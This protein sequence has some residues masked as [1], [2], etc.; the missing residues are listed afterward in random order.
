MGNENP[1]VLRNL[2]KSGYWIILTGH[3]TLI[4]HYYPCKRAELDINVNVGLN[5]V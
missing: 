5:D 2:F 3:L 1:G 4:N